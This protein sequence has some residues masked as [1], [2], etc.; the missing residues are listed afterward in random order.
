M[1][2]TQVVLRE[3][4]G[5]DGEECRG[6]VEGLGEDLFG[7]GVIRLQSQTLLG[8]VAVWVILGL[9]VKRRLWLG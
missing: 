2:G 8:A 5:E 9:R 4:G 6:S 3:A 7:R 1:P